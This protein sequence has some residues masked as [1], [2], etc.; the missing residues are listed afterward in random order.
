MIRSDADTLLN[1]VE[2]IDAIL[3]NS[4]LPISGPNGNNRLPLVRVGKFNRDRSRPKHV[5]D[6][7]LFS[8]AQGEESP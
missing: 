4:D 2:N 5:R 1:Q 3:L 7:H 8:L 6:R